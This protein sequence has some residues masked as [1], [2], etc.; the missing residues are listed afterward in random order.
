MNRQF[1]VLAEI[2]G[3]RLNLLGLDAF[4]TRHPERETDYDLRDLIVAN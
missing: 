3:K 2:T 1:E 4:G